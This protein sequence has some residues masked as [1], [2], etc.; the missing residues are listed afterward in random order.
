MS[1]RKEFLAFAVERLAVLG[2]VTARAMFGGHGLYCEGLFIA[3]VTGEQLWFKADALTQPDFEARGLQRFTYSARGKPVQLRYYAAP[4]EV[5]DE[6]PAMRAWGQRA[7]AAALRARK[8][9]P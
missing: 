5:F 1:Q 4:P 6:P 2:P 8:D 7:L 9:R 3:I